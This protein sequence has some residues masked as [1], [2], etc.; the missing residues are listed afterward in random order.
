VRSVGNNVA[1]N[2]WWKHHVDSAI[3]LDSCPP[4]SIDDTLTLDKLMLH[5]DGVQ[6]VSD[7]TQSLRLSLL[8]LARNCKRHLLNAIEYAFA[9][10]GYWSQR[11]D[12][13]LPSGVEVWGQDVTSGSLG[14]LDDIQPVRTSS[15]CS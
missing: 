11:A 7:D 6:S 10:V 1:V 5:G 4:S 8:L 9:N 15:S 3:N 13:T 12:N 2:V 14:L